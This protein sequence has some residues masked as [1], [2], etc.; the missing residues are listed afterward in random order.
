M[1]EVVCGFERTGAAFGYMHYSKEVLPDLIC[2]AKGISGGMVPFGAVW[3]SQKIAKHYEDN[4]LC[5]GLTNYAHPLGIAAM[6]GV[7]E[8]VQNPDFQKN[9][10]SV[11]KVFLSELEKLKKSQLVKDIRVKGML[12]A[13]DLNKTISNKNFFDK[14]LYL[15]SQTNRL[16]LAPPLIITK[17]ELEN[18]MQK[19]FQVLKGEEI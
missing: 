11:E 9:L 16:I 3:T 14:G 18:G 8:I 19:I 5:C 7:L 4:L 1:D 2:L 12:C 15:V 17:S 6:R 10:K 13:I